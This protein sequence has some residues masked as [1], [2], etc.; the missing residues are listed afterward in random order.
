MDK[1]EKIILVTGATGTQGKAVALE[2]LQAGFKVRAQA[3]KSDATDLEKAGAEI[4]RGSCDDMEFLTKAMQGVYGL[5]SVQTPDITGDDVERRHAK[6][7]AEAALKSGV[8]QVVHASVS[9]VG[10]HENFPGWHEG[11]WEEGFQK[12]WTD[13]DD[14]MKSMVNTG[15]EYWTVLNPAM[16]MENYIPPKVYYMYPCLKQD[17]ILT[18]LHVDTES[19]LIA[20]ED[21]G[22]FAAAAF[23][24]PKAFH[25]KLIGLAGD[26]L[27]TTAI[28]EKLG[29]VNGKKINAVHLSPQEALARGVS[30]M[31]V[32]MEEW[33]NEV[34]HN[35]DIKGLKEYGIHLTSFDEWLDK[36]KKELL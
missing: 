12:Y 27:T 4:V 13:K 31:G 5:F 30:S 2:L 16:F 24:D 20:A 35:V 18:S 9:Q 28:A 11:R 15:F 3:F 36:H 17:E 22:K 7:L 8:K 1:A 21:I 19:H 25:G 6:N 34:G 26:L 33:M 29:K 32:V 10:N 14:A 23:K